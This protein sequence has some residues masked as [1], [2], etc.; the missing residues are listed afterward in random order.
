MH[1]FAAF[2]EANNIGNAE[3]QTH[4]YNE[5]I[6]SLKPDEGEYSKDEP[7]NRLRTKEKLFNT[8]RSIHGKIKR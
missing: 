4:S 1:T 2:S 3:G 5:E 7:Q 6:I 8:Y